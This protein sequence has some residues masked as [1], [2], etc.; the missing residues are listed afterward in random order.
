MFVNN[1]RQF[2]QNLEN[3]CN[4]EQIA[5]DR[6]ETREFWEGIWSVE[7]K[8]NTRAGWIGRVK[9]KMSSVQRQDD[10]EISVQDVRNVLRM[11]PNWKAAGPDG[12]QGFWLKNLKCL[13]ERMTHL[14]QECRNTS[15][16][17]N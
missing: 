13:H 12:V 3:K 15:E 9:E 7:A 4:E 11:V 1:Q 2:Y 8:H 10:L 17:P 5:P 14:L 16:C 6:E